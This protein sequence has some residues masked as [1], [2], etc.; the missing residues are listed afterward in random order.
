M[1]LSTG[2]QR[3][4]AHRFYEEKTGAE[5]ASYVYKPPFE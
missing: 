2:L 5:R 3:T 4:D 1:A